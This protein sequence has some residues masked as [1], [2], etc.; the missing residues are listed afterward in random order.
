MTLNTVL[1]FNMYE[2]ICNHSTLAIFGKLCLFFILSALAQLVKV[3]KAWPELAPEPH[4]HLPLLSC[5]EPGGQ[6]GTPLNNGHAGK[7]LFL[8]GFKNGLKG[9]ATNRPFYLWILISKKNAL[10]IFC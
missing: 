4:Y 1:S 5:E 10:D 8:V 7:S 6:V 9:I 3:L 2:I